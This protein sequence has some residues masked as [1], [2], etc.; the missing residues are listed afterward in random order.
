MPRNP[1]A[2]LLAA[3]LGRLQDGAPK[4]ALRIDR[5]SLFE[6]LVCGLRKSGIGDISAVVG[7]H[8]DTLLEL[9]S[10]CDVRVIRQIHT[11]V[12]LVIPQSM[13]EQERLRNHPGVELML[14]VADAPLV[15]VKD[16]FS[17]SGYQGV[18]KREGMQG[19]AVNW[20]VAMRPGKRKVLNKNTPIGTSMDRLEQAKTPIQA[21]VE[22]PFMEIERQLGHLNVRYQPW[23]RM[24]R[25]CTRR[26]CCPPYGPCNARCCRGCRDVFGN[27]PRTEIKY[28]DILDV[29][30]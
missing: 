27:P 17:E 14:L 19:I 16:I 21:K 2:T 29:A 8:P 15:T 30:G 5:E 11:G 3:G 23:L 12:D 6:R 26:L 20:H 18:S 9:E 4:S 7:P 1:A 25:N 24:R 10:R 13:A 28:I 22:Y